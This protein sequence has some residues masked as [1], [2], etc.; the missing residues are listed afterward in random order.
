MLLR[1]GKEHL[2]NE[3]VQKLVEEDRASYKPMFLNWRDIVYVK[4]LDDT[5]CK[6]IFISYQNKDPN[7][8]KMIWA[9]E[10]ENDYPDYY[11]EW[12]RIN[13]DSFNR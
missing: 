13:I 3:T 12:V 2:Y 1:T 9:I 7:L 5:W 10:E 8:N 6:A 11:T 4:T